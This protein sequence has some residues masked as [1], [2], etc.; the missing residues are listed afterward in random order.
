VLN[1]RGV[2]DRSALKGHYDLCW[3]YHSLG[4]SSGSSLIFE[5]MAVIK[6]NRIVLESG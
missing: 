5:A 4:F 6:Q 1:D 3:S 2:R